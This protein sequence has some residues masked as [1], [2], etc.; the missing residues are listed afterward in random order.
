MEGIKS[1][2]HDLQFET[3]VKVCFRLKLL[4]GSSILDELL[5]YIDKAP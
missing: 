5:A 4:L 3:P 2:E 1:A